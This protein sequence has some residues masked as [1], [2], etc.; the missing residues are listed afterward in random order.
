MVTEGSRFELNSTAVSASE[1][2]MRRARVVV[3]SEIKEITITGMP[4]DTNGPNWDR[5]TQRI[6]FLGTSA[7]APH[8]SELV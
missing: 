1:M 3:G 6:P 7:A 5:E 4:L 2:E 8:I